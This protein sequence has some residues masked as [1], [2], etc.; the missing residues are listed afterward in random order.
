MKRPTDR[1]AV[2]MVGGAAALAAATGAASA[3]STDVRGVVTFAGGRSIP[4][5]NIKIYLENLAIQ[6]SAQRR[7]A[8]TRVNSDGGSKT[9]DFSF[10]RPASTTASPTLQIVARL[11]RADG[12]LLARGSAQ[13]K[14]SVPVEITLND[15]VY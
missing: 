6:D 3:Q 11:E 15:A 14:A 13:I 12:W 10:S 8:E 9:I 1:R 7:V 2:L 5:G 4:E